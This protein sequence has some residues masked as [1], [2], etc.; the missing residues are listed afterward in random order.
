MI[1]WLP[2]VGKMV[3]D[4]FRSWK[5][6]KREQDQQ[7]HAGQ[8]NAREQFAAEFMAPRENRTWFDSLIDGI[9]RLPRPTIVGLIIAYFI[10]SFH[11][12]V[13]FAQINQG[14]MNIP[15]P[16]WVIAGGVIGF[17][18]TLREIKHSRDG[19]AFA[20]AAE[21]AMSIEKSR[22]EFEPPEIDMESK[23]GDLARESV[24]PDERLG[25]H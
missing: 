2:A 8:T 4:G 10:L 22:M 20:K 21:N 15:E 5:G 17:Y 19:K 3:L 1:Q 12:P 24:H 23:Y 25:A 6:D 7:H 16:M 13:L 14:L 18:F 11:D 9:N